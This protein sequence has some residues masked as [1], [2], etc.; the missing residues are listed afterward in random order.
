MVGLGLWYHEGVLSSAMWSR[1]Q[2]HVGLM[3]GLG[4]WLGL[5]LGEV[6]LSDP[7]IELNLGLGLFRVRVSGGT[8]RVKVRRFVV[9]GGHKGVLCVQQH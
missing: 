9:T 8:V 2:C 5:G 3:V 7:G 6:L 4:L 1:V